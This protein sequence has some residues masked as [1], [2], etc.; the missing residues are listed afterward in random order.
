MDTLTEIQDIIRAE[1]G[2]PGEFRGEPPYELIAIGE[3]PGPEEERKGRPFI[4]RAGA[5]L[6]GMMRE[7]GLTSYYVT[8]MSKTFPGYDA[9][10]KIAKPS[11]EDLER[12]R[13]I[14]DAELEAVGVKKLLLLGKYAC[15][16]AFSGNFAM[17]DIVGKKVEQDG[18]TAYAAYHPASFL[19][20]Q[21]TAANTRNM[22]LQRRILAS[23]KGEEQIE[24][25]YHVLEPHNTTDTL[26][27]DIETEGGLDPR[28]AIITEWSMLHQ[29]NTH[30]ILSFD[31]SQRPPRPESVIFHN[32][33]FDYPVLTR[34]DPK[35]LEVTDIHDTMAM[36]YVLGYEDLSLKG[37]SNQLFGV[38]VYDYKNREECGK[39][40]YNAQDVFLTKRLFEHF[41]PQLPGTAY[42]IDRA[43]IPVLTYASL[44]SGYEI[45]KKKLE[46][47]IAV[48]E[49]EQSI[50]ERT[51]EQIY[52]GINMR[53][54]AQ[55][56]QV[57]PTKDTQADTLKDLDSGEAHLVLKHRE[58]T[59][60]LT[61]YLYPYRQRDIVSGLYRLTLASGEHGDDVGGASTGR[62]SSH[63]PNMQN[64]HPILQRCLRAPAKHDL[65]MA[66]Y[67]QIEL[68]CIAEIS[69]DKRM[70]QE[71]KEG[72]DFHAETAKLLGL[73][74]SVGKTWNFARWYGAEADKLAHITGLPVAT[75]A[76]L[77]QVQD[78]TYP[79]QREWGESHWA[80]VQATGYS[81]SPAPFLHRKR[82]HTF[83]PASAKRQ[84]L[85]H[86]AQSHAS[87][88]T[89]AAIGA[90]GYE[91]GR[92]EFVNTIHDSLH[93][94]IP[95]G[96]EGDLTAKRVCDIM[97]EVGHHY[98]PNAGIDISVKRARYWE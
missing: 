88:I 91:P 30:A 9:H 69:Q 92:L 39:E 36:A 18:Y 17:K 42:D 60:A 13:P 49:L 34:H 85:N 46:D 3:C 48:A 53:S 58:V 29:G 15:K 61:T 77:M 50:L 98:L 97:L 19:Y 76:E 73:E 52:P 20:N 22:N 75:C 10:G 4:G 47:S 86:P 55:L 12:W 38:K 90:I 45:D 21:G 35:W 89:K 64:L 32:A 80:M 2:V 67:S 24:Y 93:Y 33:L 28:T 74:R 63:D 84:A 23:V 40:Q 82:I 83:D 44:F 72:R 95:K 16:L 66:D 68:R 26:V 57:F 78:R 7:A 51:F 87:Y 96:K 27:L 43:I 81:E 65:L 41:R 70:I 6:D 71:L 56:L 5:V 59:K 11:K 62:L 94:V 8:N 54:P 14:L 25:P 37:L 31:R 79:G 1:G